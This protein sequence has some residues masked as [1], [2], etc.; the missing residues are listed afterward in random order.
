[1]KILSEVTGKT[2][3]KGLRED[4]VLF[5]MAIRLKDICNQYGV[6]IMSATQLNGDYK[7]AK[8]PDQNLLRGAKAIAD[9]IDLGAIMLGVT[10][11]DLVALENILNSDIFET[12]TIKISIYKNRRGRF[13]G[14]YL[15]CKSDLGTCRVE[16]MFCTGYDYE[17][18]SVDDIRIKVEEP[19]AF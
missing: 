14:I 18:I 4:N 17:M 15:W 1:M 6:F 11:N 9:K 13:K 8:V 5:M 12:P 10:D 19:S 3:I 7:D 2:G 16:P